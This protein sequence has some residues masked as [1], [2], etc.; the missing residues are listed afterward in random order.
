M[1][2]PYSSISFTKNAN[3]SVTKKLLERQTHEIT[4]VPVQALRGSPPSHFNIDERYHGPRNGNSRKENKAYCLGIFNISIPLIYDEGDHA[5]IQLNE[6]IDKASKVRTQLRFISN[7]AR[8][9]VLTSN[10]GLGNHLL[11]C[12]PNAIETPCN[13]YAKQH[14]PP[15]LPNTCVDLFRERYNWTDGQDERCVF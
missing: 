8:R 7:T 2:L 15:C 10:S 12:L 3:D 5:L 4:G 13:S 6:E 14:V 11:H 9:R 1:I